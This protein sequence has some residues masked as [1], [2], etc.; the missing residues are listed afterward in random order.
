MYIKPVGKYI[1]VKLIENRIDIGTV[2]DIGEYGSIVHAGDH[3]LIIP[4]GIAVE[5]VIE[6]SVE[7]IIKYEGN[8]SLKGVRYA[9]VHIDDICGVIPARTT[10]DKLKDIR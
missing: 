7:E 6:K 1:L 9:F 3:V 5:K 8:S 10:L 2:V 4:G